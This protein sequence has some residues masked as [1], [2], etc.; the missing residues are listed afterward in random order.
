METAR[1]Y[2]YP[3]PIWFTIDYELSI[4]RV[5]LMCVSGFL[6]QF[7]RVDGR[8]VE[9]LDSLGENTMIYI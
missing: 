9:K 3:T 1:T 2:H 8:K 6:K 5:S 4:C 7:R